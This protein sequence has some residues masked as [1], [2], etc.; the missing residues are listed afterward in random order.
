L[1][2]EYK[3]SGSQK[4]KVREQNRKDQILEAAARRFAHF[5]VSKTTLT[6][7]AD[8]LS[9]TKQAL[10][11]YFPDKESLISEVTRQL[12][13]AYLS[14]MEAALKGANSFEEALTRLVEFRSRA[15]QEHFMLFTQLESAG[16]LHTR[17]A[18]AVLLNLARR[19]EQLLLSACRSGIVS[20]ELRRI[21]ALQTVRTLL[22]A[23]TALATQLYRK[24][25]P[26]QQD[27]NKLVQKQKELLHLIYHGLKEPASWKN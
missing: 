10:G 27:F 21:P 19:E 4:V 1:T 24:C 8:D 18:K 20:G 7:I 5:G 11:Y 13:G 9:L 16:Q 26:D 12:V 22:V 3:K 23:I 6:E 17:S 25:L 15:F 2:S 14:Q